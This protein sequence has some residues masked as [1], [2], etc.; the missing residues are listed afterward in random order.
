M[1]YLKK[2]QAQKLAGNI[3]SSDD[4][5]AA[6]IDCLSVAAKSTVLKGIRNASRSRVDNEVQ[7]L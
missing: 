3:D 4:A 1:K 5:D 6:F 2:K 7:I